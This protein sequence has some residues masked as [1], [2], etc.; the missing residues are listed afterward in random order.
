MIL[1]INLKLDG[2]ED[3]MRQIQK[4][5]GSV[6]GAT[7]RCMNASAKV[8]DAELKTQM[9]KAGVQG[10]LIAEMPASTVQYQHG[11]LTASVGYKKGAYDP[12]N[13]ST[14]YKVL[15]LN[16]GTPHRKKHGQVK[17]RG[18]ILKAKRRAKP[19]I[20]KEQEK[21]LHEILKGL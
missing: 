5:E 7:Q 3:M 13:L 1:P 17:A 19:K 20:K 10:D 9:S 2:F 6:K 11:L 12:N 21:T 16:Y 4:A 14:G 8:M 18:F 15:F